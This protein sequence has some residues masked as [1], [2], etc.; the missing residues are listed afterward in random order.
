MKTAILTFQD[1]VNYGA[2]LQAYALQTA[3]HK[4]IPQNEAGILDHHCAVIRDK[5]LPGFVEKKG[6]PVKGYLKMLKNYRVKTR[7][8]SRFEQFKSE[9]LNLIPYSSEE[10]KSRFLKEYDAITVGSDQVWNTDLTAGDRTYFLSEFKPMKRFSYAASIGKESIEEKDIPY[11]K[12]LSELD[13]I[14]VREESAKAILNDIIP[15][16][17]SVVPDPVLLLE[18]EEWRK[19]E[20]PVEDLKPQSYVLLYYFKITKPLVDFARKKAAEY[21]CELVCIQGTGKK[22]PDTRTIRDASPNEFL[23]LIDNAKCVV[24]TSF[25]GTMFSV[26]FEKEFYSETKVNRATRIVEVLNRYGMQSHMLENAQ[27]VDAP[28]NRAES[29]RLAAE[30]RKRGLDFISGMKTKMDQR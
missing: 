17:V 9:Y 8:K 11:F 26:I 4:T 7:R 1:A 6:N 30:D 23:W 18:K 21:G 24:T 20:R 27:P 5:H 13:G 10:D 22:I 16:E 3:L 19:I 25:H 12:E 29:N 2:I 14:A 28:D 15:N